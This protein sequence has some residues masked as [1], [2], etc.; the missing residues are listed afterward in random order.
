MTR[1][2]R[3]TVNDDFELILM[4]AMRNSMA[5]PTASYQPI[6]TARYITALLPYLSNGFIAS[7]EREIVMQRKHKPDRW[8]AVWDELLSSAVLEKNRRKGEAGNG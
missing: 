5:E 8:C 7:T 1:K 6:F 2:H 4:Y 3:I